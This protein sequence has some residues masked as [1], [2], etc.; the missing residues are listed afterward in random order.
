MQQQIKP[1]LLDIETSLYSKLTVTVEPNDL[2]ATISFLQKTWQEEFPGTPFVYAFLD[3]YFDKQ[4]KLEDQIGRMVSIVSLLGMF[5]AS[6]GLLGLV[7]FY[8][9][10]R[11]REISIRKVFGSSVSAVISYYSCKFIKIILFTIIVAV[12]VSRKLIS[13]W[14][15]NYAYQVKVGVWPYATACL[16]VLIISSLVVSLRCLKAASTNPV[17]ALKYE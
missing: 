3:E 12:P 15:Q 7:S 2:P 13:Y 4:Y 14:L 16:F 17:K 1:L 10:Q 6:I 9:A 11:T 5:I 8:I